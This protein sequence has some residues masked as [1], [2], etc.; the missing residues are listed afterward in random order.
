MPS[1][2]EDLNLNGQHPPKKL[3]MPLTPAMGN[4]SIHKELAGQLA[5]QKT[6]FPIRCEK[7]TA[8]II[9]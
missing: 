1:E 5:W 8:N 9:L 7:K 3:R 6:E 4:T 2:H